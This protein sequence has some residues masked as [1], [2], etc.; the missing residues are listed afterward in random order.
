M[1]KARVQR[2]MAKIGSSRCS[3]VDSKMLHLKKAETFFLQSTDVPFILSS[4]AIP[5]AGKRRSPLPRFET[6][7][8]A[9]GLSTPHPCGTQVPQRLLT[10]LRRRTC[11]R[12]LPSTDSRECWTIATHRHRSFLRYRPLAY[13]S[14]R[15]VADESLTRL[16]TASRTHEP[17]QQELTRLVLPPQTQ[18]L[19]AS[20][21]PPRSNRGGFPLAALLW[22]SSLS[23]APAR[24]GARKGGGKGA[25]L[26]AAKLPAILSATKIEP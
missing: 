26:P 8:L 11:A 3:A 18:S 25:R 13:R 16:R 12:L 14:G 2:N 21:Q 10:R 9:T 20:T 4:F 5:L 7:R 1:S 15:G 19:A 6:V 24:R 22:S 23:L 17:R